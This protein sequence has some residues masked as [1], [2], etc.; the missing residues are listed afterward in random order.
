M[1][2]L[3]YMR[4]LYQFYIDVKSSICILHGRRKL[5]ISFT[6]GLVVCWGWKYFRQDKILKGRAISRPEGHTEKSKGILG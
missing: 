6:K 1:V 3:L 4:L 5:V 2:D